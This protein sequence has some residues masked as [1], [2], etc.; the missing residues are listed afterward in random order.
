MVRRVA[1]CYCKMWCNIYMGEGHWQANTSRHWHTFKLQQT[2]SEQSSYLI[3]KHWS[4]HHWSSGERKAT[5]TFCAWTRN[6][7]EAYSNGKDSDILFCVVDWLFRKHFPGFDVELLSEEILFIF[8]YIILQH[9]F[10]LLL[11]LF[12]RQSMRWLN[13]ICD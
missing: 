1:R 10:L 8:Y 9:T 7:F 3:D 4:I 12:D 11:F 13:F 5:T 2:I 6:R